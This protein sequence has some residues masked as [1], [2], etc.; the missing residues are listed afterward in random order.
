MGTNLGLLVADGGVDNDIV[1]LV[2]VDGGG[3]AEAV[4]G[5]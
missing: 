4:T 3:D 1:A 2:P 5:L